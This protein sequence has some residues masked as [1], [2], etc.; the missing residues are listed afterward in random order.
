MRCRAGE[1]ES[2]PSISP[3]RE[4]GRGLNL[5]WNFPMRLR[6]PPAAVQE[7]SGHRLSDLLVCLWDIVL[8]FCK[9]V[10]PR[11]DTGGF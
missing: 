1:L 10:G 7:Q 5:P 4:D 2:Q 11:G 6:S 8:H 3:K 9:D